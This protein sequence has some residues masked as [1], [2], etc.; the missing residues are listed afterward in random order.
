MRVL[1]CLL[2]MTSMAFAITADETSYVN[3]KLA[4]KKLET[5]RNAK[6]AERDGKLTTEEVKYNA[7]KQVIM[8]NYEAQIDALEAQIATKNTAFDTLVNKP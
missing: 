3:I 6:I 8:D 4:I 5:R 7:A 1:I 2:L